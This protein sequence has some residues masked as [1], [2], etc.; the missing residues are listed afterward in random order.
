MVIADDRPTDKTRYADRFGDS[1]AGVKAETFEWLGT[2]EL[3]VV[4]FK[5]GALTFGSASLAVVPLNSAFFALALM[6]LQG[7]VTFD[8]IGAYTP[9]SILYVA[10]PFRQTHFDNKH[11]ITSYNVCYTKLLR[12][13]V[14]RD[15][16]IFAGIA[17]QYVLISAASAYQTPPRHYV[18]SE[19][20]P[21]DNPFWE[22]SRN[23][24]S[25]EARLREESAARGLQFTI[26]RPSHTYG[27][28]D[29]PAA[30]TSWTHPW[31]WAQR[32]ID[33]DPVLM[34]GDGTSLWTLTV[35]TSYSIHYT[36]LYERHGGGVAPGGRD[37]LHAGQ[38]LALAA[39]RSNELGDSYNFV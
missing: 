19:R 4:P 20:T 2:H 13:E 22:Y 24:A 26:V 8:E 12:D 6:D 30:I 17:G 5:A 21:L 10:P 28:S 32:L 18:T 39:R 38:V 27:Y 1:F 23:K 31:T 34:H 16:E 37:A 33:G 11:R 3:V 15:A 35:I 25:A 9:R 36:K 7:W 14:A 29:L